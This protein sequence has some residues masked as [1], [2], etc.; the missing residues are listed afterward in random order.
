MYS[1]DLVSGAGPEGA[2]VAAGQAAGQAPHCG[3]YVRRASRRRATRYAHLRAALHLRRRLRAP[4]CSAA[5]VD[6]L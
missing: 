6:C 2:Q 1:C 3:G 5:P 4:R